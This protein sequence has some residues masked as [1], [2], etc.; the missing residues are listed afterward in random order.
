MKNLIINKSMKKFNFKYMELVKKSK[1]TSV[2][3]VG[4]WPFVDQEQQRGQLG[5][6]N[7]QSRS[8]MGS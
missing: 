7:K 6:G 2:P 8:H 1:F 4:K 3:K 5:G